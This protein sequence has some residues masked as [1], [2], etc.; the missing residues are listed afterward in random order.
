MSRYKHGVHTPACARRRFWW[1]VF[2][3]AHRSE[4][5][6]G[7][8]Q[9]PARAAPANLSYQRPVALSGRGSY[10]IWREIKTLITGY[11][12]E[13]ERRREWGAKR[14]LPYMLGGLLQIH[15]QQS[16][17]Y[18]VR[19]SNHCWSSYSFFMWSRRL[20]VFG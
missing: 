5:A 14:P 18:N 8:V 1:D 3:T 20:S 11:P 4:S 12:R 7:Y 16:K 2:L 6:L 10:M 17:I 9:L 13:G 19:C 15:V